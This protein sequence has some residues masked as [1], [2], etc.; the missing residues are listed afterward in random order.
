MASIIGY[1]AHG[2]NYQTNRISHSFIRKY[3][4]R[5]H[6]IVGI[7][8]LLFHCDLTDASA[9]GLALSVFLVGYLVLFS[10]RWKYC[11]I[12]SSLR[13][14]HARSMFIGMS[15]HPEH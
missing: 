5:S 3:V 1:R 13:F 9:T 2:L 15:I 10:V 11:R 8:V 6:G 4:C 14:H 7:H 12:Y